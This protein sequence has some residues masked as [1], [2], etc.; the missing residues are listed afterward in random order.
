MIFLG[1][2]HRGYELKE[3][4]KK[5]FDE[6]NIDYIDCG[7]NSK[8]I[9]HYPLIVKNVYS[10]MDITKDKA[11]LICGSGVG[12]SIAANKFKGIR[13]GLCYNKV[14]VED[15]KQ[16]GN[17]NVLVLAGDLLSIEQSVEIIEEWQN[18]EFLKGRYSDR[19]K[20]LEE[21]EKENMK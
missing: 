20:M 18:L 21:I 5:Y 10:K 8:E 19:L 6:K 14:A 11:I 4:I 12:M 13:A 16:H 9:T 2:D 3:K 7:T 15:A 1:A 17:I